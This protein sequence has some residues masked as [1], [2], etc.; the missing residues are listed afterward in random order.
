MDLGAAYSRLVTRNEG[1]SLEDFKKAMEIEHILQ[2][3]AGKIADLGSKIRGK[4]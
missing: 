3:A 4:W 2:E 1:S